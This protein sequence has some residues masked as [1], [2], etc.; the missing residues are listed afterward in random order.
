MVRDTSAAFPE[1]AAL[2]ARIDATTVAAK[3]VYFDAGT[4]SDSLFRS[5][6]PANIIVLGA[7][8]QQGVI[9]IS[10]DAIERAIELNGVAVESNI[11]AFRIGRKIAVDPTWIETMGLTRA[12]DVKRSEKRKSKAADKMIA[13]IG[14]TSEELARLLSIRVPDLIDYQD[15]AYAKQ[16]VAKVAEV[17]A[18]ESA[19]GEDSRLSEAVARYLYKLMAYKDEYEVARLH[20]SSAFKDTLAEQFGA[21]AQITYKL[22]PPTMRQFGYDSKIGLGKSGE[23][24]FAAL[25]RMKKLRGTSMDPFGRTKHRK[26]ERELITEYEAMIDKVLTKLSADNFDWA[27]EVA[28][29]P[30]IVRGYE[31]IKEDNIAEFRSKAQQL[32]K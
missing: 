19:V 11:Q 16:Y 2:Q 31:G 30:D 8:Y 15:A 28:E 21:G 25:A 24:A 12:G 7:G 26:M 14:N 6:M 23:V 18:A 29:L 22:H 13:G 17:R 1:W 27:V 10:A 4:V 3:N 20:R 32:L 5:H 9:P